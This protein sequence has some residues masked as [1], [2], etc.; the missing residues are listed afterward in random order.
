MLIVLEEEKTLEHISADFRYVIHSK[1]WLKPGKHLIASL[2]N[3]PIFG[4]FFECYRRRRSKFL[5]HL[6]RYAV[7]H[8]P[9]S[10]ELA[11]F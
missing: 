9:F 4:I 3:L 6:I 1:H 11:H 2:N 10:C 8:D 5:Y 7:R